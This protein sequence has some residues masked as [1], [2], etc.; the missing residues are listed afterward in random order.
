MNLLV[1][2]PAPSMHLWLV[3]FLACGDSAPGG[4]TDAGPPD[5]PAM[6]SLPD[7]PDPP[8]TTAPTID[9]TTTTDPTITTTTAPATTT[10]DTT[11]EP[12][13]TCG[14]GVQ[15]PGEQ[16]DDGAANDDNAFCTAHCLLNFCG[17]G[18]LLVGWE[19]C[20]EGIANSDAYG[21]TCSAHCTPAPRCGD[22]IQQPEFD[23]QCDLGPDNGGPIGD[24]QGILCGPT[25]RIQALRAF[26]SS[27]AFSGNLSGLGGADNRCRDAASAAGLSQ[28]HRFHAY[29]ST[30]DSP[31]NARFPGPLAQP[32]PYILITGK[33]LADSHAALLAQ[34]PLGEGL[35][36]TELGTT[37]LNERVAT[38]TAPNG[39]AFPGD[40]HCQAW[41]SADP[42]F[43]ART[44][45]TFPG[46]PG[47]WQPWLINGAWTSAFT[48]KCD[49]AE[50][51][52]YCL[53]I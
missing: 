1:P 34:G 9:T 26:V 22:H 17:D 16:C 41:T 49:K 12:A 32:L 19:I 45:I 8:P 3:I 4:S 5:D 47:D 38:N 51:H 35:S 15:D 13:P 25:C 20:D 46:D 29:L 6:T 28:P 33:K 18:H 24:E 14:D 44:G 11:V 50:L 43:E 2:R 21:S 23:E 36:V 31:A 40:H 48:R 37:L 10:T 42:E 53:E 52:L 30:P 27:Q 7:L 39:S